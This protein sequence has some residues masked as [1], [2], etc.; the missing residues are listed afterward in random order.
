MKIIFLGGNGRFGKTFKKVSKILYKRNFKIEHN[1]KDYK[2]NIRCV[3]S[4][5]NR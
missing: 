4:K 2:D 1:L 3:I 5:L